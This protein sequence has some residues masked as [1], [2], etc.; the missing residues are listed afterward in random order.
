MLRHPLLLST[1]P[2]SGFFSG[3]C[4]RESIDPVTSAYI[5]PRCFSID[6]KI[7]CMNEVIHIYLN[8]RAFQ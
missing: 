4:L 5:D 7:I 1:K 6:I 2:P 3:L 8:M